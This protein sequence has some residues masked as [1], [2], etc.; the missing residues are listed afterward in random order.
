MIPRWY[1]DETVDAIDE[2][3]VNEPG[4]HPVAAVPTG[5]GK[6]LIIGMLIDRLLSKQPLDNILVLSHV[7]EI[8]EQNYDALVD[9][10]D[11]YDIGLYSAGL[12]SKTISK[13]TVAGIQSVYR[14][15][16]LF[17]MFDYIIID[18]AHLITV[19]G[20]GMYRT[21]LKALAHCPYIG[22]TA[23]PFRLGHG[24]IYE[25]EGAI[26]TKLAYDLTS[27]EN[28]NRLVK[29]GFLSRVISKTTKLKMD[30][31]GIKHRAKEFAQDEL[32]AKFDR[33]EITRAAIYE[34]LHFGKKY[35]KWLLFAIDIDHAENIARILR[36]EG[37]ETACVH[38][39]MEGDRKEVISDI[40][41]GK[42]RATVNVNVLTT[43]FDVPD[44]DFIALLRPTES[45][46]VY[47]QSVGR[48]LRIAPGKDHCLVLDFAGNVARLGP[49][50]E[51]HVTQKDKTDGN[52]DPILKVCPDCGC[53]QPGAVRVCDIC[54]HEFEFVQ[55]IT[56]TASTAE[57]VAE[58]VEE[59]EEWVKVSNVNYSI[60][61]K[62]GSPSSLK[63]TYRVGLNSFSEWIA[64][65]YKGYA[66]H[67]AHSWVRFRLPSDYSMP[68]DVSELYKASSY[69]MKPTE[70]LVNLSKKFPDIKDS[71][72]A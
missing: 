53:Y 67:K 71:R 46:V 12:K 45:P 62:A 50:N 51:V 65:D 6:T 40:K 69:L 2:V 24:Y 8:L 72:F 4:E 44:I 29:E 48:G 20:D 3:L 25:G 31:D 5:G 61:N 27:K 59:I 1:Q 15:P 17:K 54:G 60:H 35:K 32:S 66:K 18:E 58:D 57:I 10:Y 56:M 68:A 70:I 14:K 33:E 7:E 38:S 13:I 55:K 63:V 39:K 9:Y 26:F 49:I 16:E 64:Y 47:V 30:T 28:F 43:G 52:G 34:I 19:Q 36:E 11:G 22:L 37:I 21:F 41:K 42:Y 23:T